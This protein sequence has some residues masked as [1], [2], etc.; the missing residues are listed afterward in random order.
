MNNYIIGSGYFEHS[1]RMRWFYR[2]WAQNTLDHSSAERV[3]V[4]C[5]GRKP[6]VARGITVIP[7]TG[8]LGH[9]GAI[10]RKENNP[11]NHAYCGWSSHMLTLAMI[12]YS[13]CTDFIYKEQDCLAFGNWVH[14]M[15]CDAR[16]RMMVYGQCQ[17]MGVA[18][19]L[20][21]V[22]H[23]FIPDFVRFY[24]NLSDD[25]NRHMLPEHKFL[26][27]HHAF[28]REVGRLSFGFD[29]DR[30]MD[31]EAPAFYAQK[32]TRT[33]LQEMKDAGLIPCGTFIP[34]GCFSYRQFEA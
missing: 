30:P 5:C 29:R 14:Q 9:I 25:R 31:F 2:I 34:T 27:I 32:L 17:L 8:N 19:S 1:A 7:A 3:Y 21:L 16:G 18:Q 12:A 22:K 23:A 20:F 28:R 24:L 33:E 10:F 15:Y 4:I 13:N 11:N 6:P 26:A